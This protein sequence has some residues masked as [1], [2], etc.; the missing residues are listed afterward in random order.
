MP[1]GVTTRGQFSSQ[2]LSLLWVRWNV[3]YS[4]QAYASQRQ[5]ADAW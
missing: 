1:Q 4:N 2:L 3:S 5:H